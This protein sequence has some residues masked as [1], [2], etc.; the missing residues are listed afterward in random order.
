MPVVR[1]PVRI[2]SDHS[3]DVVFDELVSLPT[4][5]FDLG[6][7]P[8]R[9]LIVTDE[10]VAT[11][12]LDQVDSSLRR[13]GWDPRPISVPPG[14]TSKSLTELARLYDFALANPVDR[15]TPVI[16]LG[17]GVVGDLT[18]F[19]AATL[20]RG[21]PLVHVATTLIAQVDSAI[22]G[23]TG[24]NH[25]KGKNLV[26]SFY[27]PALV[28]SDV[29]T[30]T[31]LPSREWAAG[32]SE[33]VKHGLISG[34]K[35]TKDLIDSWEGLAGRDRAVL[36]RLL[37]KSAR[38]K[39]DIV[40]RDER[41]AGIRAFLNFGHSVGHAI[42][43][44]AGYGRVLHGEAVAVGMEVALHLSQARYPE[45]DFGPAWAILKRLPRPAVPS[46]DRRQILEA[47][48]YDK[49]RKSGRWRFVLLEG[50]GHP[51]LVTDVTA[52][53]VNAGLDAVIEK[54]IE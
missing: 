24:V 38:V 12:Y 3:Y 53:E 17:G 27:Q 6:L 36:S 54:T 8:G 48:D 40:Q 52:D 28:L 43:L 26:G 19:F 29:N 47:L 22:G 10:N 16:S 25:A 23:K 21:L 9:C 2:T 5:L 15:R 32:L 7:H 34:R 50:L 18:G 31:T 39:I 35:L 49:K 20:L 41:E 11:L 1:L 30:L 45:A 46:L 14:E 33:V 51:R 37:P 13:E 44:V 42:E 4:H